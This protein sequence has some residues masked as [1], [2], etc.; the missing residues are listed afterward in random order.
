MK[1]KAL[2]RWKYASFSAK[3][4]KT[5][6]VFYLARQNLISYIQGTAS[7]EQ[8]SSI[9]RL[10]HRNIHISTSHECIGFINHWQGN[11]RYAFSALTLLV[12]RQEGHLACK[13]NWVV[14]GWFIF[15]VPAH[16]GSP[17]K[18]AV[19]W[20]KWVCDKVTLHCWRALRWKDFLQQLFPDNADC[21][22]I[23]QLM[24]LHPKTP[25]FLASFK[26]QTGFT[27]WYWLTQ[28]VL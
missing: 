16:L 26:M 19:K 2:K 1:A 23:V 20:I 5:M 7:R 15:L 21:M 18:R 14:I 17:G 8:S 27:F 10:F 13:K 25:S 12:G 9:W 4:I 3:R 11:T 28:A 22:H 6:A 24:P